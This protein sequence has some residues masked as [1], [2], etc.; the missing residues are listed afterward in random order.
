MCPDVQVEARWNL[1]ETSALTIIVVVM[2]Y[3]LIK[4]QYVL[5]PATAHLGVTTLRVAY[6][7]LGVTSIE[8]QKET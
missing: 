5:P 6:T 2:V 8:Y 4:A 7:T 3:L 1:R